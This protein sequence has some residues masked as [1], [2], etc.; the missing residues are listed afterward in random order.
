MVAAVIVALTGGTGFVG[1]RLLDLLTAKG[2]QVQAL[3]RSPQQPREA[4]EWVP[5]SLSDAGSVD[6]LVAGADA[7]IHVA[8]VINA[9]STAEFE[10]G[11]RRG[12]ACGGSAPVRACLF[13]CREASVALALRRFKGESRGCGRGVSSRLDDRAAAGGLWSG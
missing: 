2:I 9:R 4:V 6:A 5:G 12:R 3:A 8:G 10:A 13:S 1:S 11:G 7:V